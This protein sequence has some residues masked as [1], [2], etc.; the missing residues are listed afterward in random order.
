MKNFPQTLKSFDAISLDEMNKV[1][2]LD[3]V[4]R[5]YVFHSK[6]LS[7][8]LAELQKD[9]FVLEINGKNF[10]AYQTIYFDTPE[11]EMYTQHHNGK[12]NRYKV[13]FRT[14]VDS[15]LSFFEIKFKTNK[16][17]TLKSRMK[18]KSTDFAIENEFED[19]L[20]LK[21]KYK[22]SMLVPALQIN[23][24]RITLVNRNKTERLTIDLMLEY[25]TNEKNINFPSMIIAEVK[26]DKSKGSPFINLMQQER[27]NNISLSKYCM[28]ISSTVKDVKHNNFKTKKRYVNKQFPT[29]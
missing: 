20:E 8:I 24:N 5:K 9:Y 23:Y 29:N 19:F 15:N 2:L 17:R 18:T 16:G 21:T 28:G 26:Q 1:K 13:R 6:M 7:G 3:R 25:T 11:Y 22:A 27:V 14:Y 4:D 12:L 10:A